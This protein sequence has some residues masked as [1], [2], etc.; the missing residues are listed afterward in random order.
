[1]NMESSDFID[2]RKSLFNFVLKHGSYDFSSGNPVIKYDLH[3]LEKDLVNNCVLDKREIVGLTDIPQ[4][5]WGIK[6][7]TLLST[8]VKKKIPQVRLCIL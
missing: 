1:M 3:G 2:C 4:V 7:I 5:V 6:N 8:L